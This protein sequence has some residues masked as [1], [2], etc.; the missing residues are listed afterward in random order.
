MEAHPESITVKI[1][2]PL[3]RAPNSFMFYNLPLSSTVEELQ[4]RITDTLPNHPPPETQKLIARGKYLSN[5]KA[6]TLREA[7]SPIDVSNS[8]SRMVV[9]ML[10]LTELEIGKSV[11]DALDA[12]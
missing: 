3:M 5:G 11:N 1:I 4:R 8:R 2:C 12:P 6:T 7:L 9:S 10:S